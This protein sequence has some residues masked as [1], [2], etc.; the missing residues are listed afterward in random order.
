MA[1]SQDMTPFLY[2]N[3]TILRRWSLISGHPRCVL[4]PLEVG[5]CSQEEIQA[6][7]EHNQFVLESVAAAEQYEAGGAPDQPDQYIL[8]LVEKRAFGVTEGFQVVAI[9]DGASAITDVLAVDLDWEPPEIAESVLAQSDWRVGGTYI[10]GIYNAPPV[11]TPVPS[12]VTNFQARA[13]MRAQI[14][15]TGLSLETTVRNMLWD[16]KTAAAQLPESHP[17][18]IA[19]DQAWLAWEQSNEFTRAGALINTLAEA[20]ALSLSQET[21]DN[22]FRM[23]AGIEA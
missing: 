7:T 22:W 5:Y 20:P 12:S 17:N 11:V 14:L 13:L 4:S 18:R 1:T 10:D 16:A 15:S 19:A 23:A 3:D 6:A 21:I 2:K 9:L 8:D